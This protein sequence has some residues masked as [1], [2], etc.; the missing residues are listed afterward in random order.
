MPPP[1]T[2][3]TAKITKVPNL[4][5]MSICKKPPLSIFHLKRE[6]PLFKTYKH[7]VCQIYKLSLRNPAVYIKLSTIYDLN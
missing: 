1:I 6:P 2:A 3:G 4:L 5:L 7:C